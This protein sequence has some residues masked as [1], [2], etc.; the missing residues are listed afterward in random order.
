MARYYFFCMFCDEFERNF[1]FQRSESEVK[2]HETDLET[3]HTKGH[4]TAEQKRSGT[5]FHA[6]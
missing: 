2:R 3:V 4:Q 5:L 6:N 1:V